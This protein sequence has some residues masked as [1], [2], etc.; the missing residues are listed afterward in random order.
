MRRTG[1]LSLGTASQ[2]NHRCPEK[3]SGTWRGPEGQGYCTQRCGNPFLEAVYETIAQKEL[4]WEGIDCERYNLI[5]QENY[6]YLRDSYLRY[7]SLLGVE[8][9]HFPGTSAGLGIAHLY[10]AMKDMIGI[11]INLNLEQDNGRLYFNLWQTH[12]WGEKTLYYFP[13]E[14]TRRLRPRLR[15]VVLSFYHELMHSNGIWTI[16]DSDDL[17]WAMEMLSDAGCDGKETPSQRRRR[18]HNVNSYAEGGSIYNRLARVEKIS[19]YKNLSKAIDSYPCADDNERM[20]IDYLRKGMQFVHAGKSLMDYC[21]DPFYEEETD[22][23]PMPMEQQIRIVYDSNGMVEG[24]MVDIFNCHCQET[25][26]LIPITTFEVTPD[27]DRAFI[28]EDDY[29][30][31]FFRWADTFLTFIDQFL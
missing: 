7:A 29:P 31:R 20:L 15:R 30:E 6:E 13:I 21:Y 2:S 3:K 16:K 24:Q 17:F 26:E 27:T 19:Y 1:Y 4:I 5:T 14:F 28:L 8:P 22:F 11:K 12:E 25:Y 23:I 18:L 10:H 9:A